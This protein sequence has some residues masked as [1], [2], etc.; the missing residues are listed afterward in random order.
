MELLQDWRSPRFE[1]ELS[2]LD[3]SDVA[4]EFL[5]R[6]KSY[7]EDYV[8]YLHGQ[9]EIASGKARNTQAIGRLFRRWGLTFPCRSL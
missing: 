6:N 2:H 8:A 9:D 7:R 1:E 3:R 4:F 5:R